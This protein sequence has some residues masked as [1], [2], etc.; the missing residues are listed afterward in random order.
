MKSV[1]GEND[2]DIKKGCKMVL[3]LMAN[4]NNSALEFH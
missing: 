2:K 4:F 1:E 3:Q